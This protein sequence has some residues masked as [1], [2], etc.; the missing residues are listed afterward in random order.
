[1]NIYENAATDGIASFF[2]QE[3]LWKKEILFNFLLKPFGLTVNDIKEV[4]TQ[5]YL[6]GTIPDF[7]IITEKDEIKFEVK[8]NNT[9][10]TS[11]EMKKKS[12]DAFLIRKNYTSSKDIPKG[13]KILNWEDLFE[14]IDKK[15]ANNEFTR[16]ALVRE[17]MKEPE[18]TLLLSP[19]EVA[20]FYSP[21]TIRAVYTMS[22]KI[23]E[24]CRNFLD[25]NK[26]RFES[27]ESH[28]QTLE[29][30]QKNE[31]GIG[32]FFQEKNG[33]KREFF[34]G[35]DPNA[36]KEFYWAINLDIDYY[37]NDKGVYT[38]GHYAFFPLDK[39]ILA[40]CTNEQDLQEEFNKNVNDVLN[41]I[42]EQPSKNAK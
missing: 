24:L 37:K 41:S 11:S 1:M 38:N 36:P 4:K 22:N 16:L 8:I 19:L 21:E 10:L 33:K 28:N 23:L 26:K 7:K 14:I 9:R 2:Y 39:E 35:L 15:E 12:R 5:D 17:Y 3:P 32:F 40:K 20:M 13:L 30:P 29:N 31:T 6:K 27:K 18:H 25:S 42:D 34:I